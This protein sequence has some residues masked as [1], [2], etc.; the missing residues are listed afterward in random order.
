MNFLLHTFVLVDQFACCHYDLFQP[1]VKYGSIGWALDTWPACSQ[2][3][4][5]EMKEERLISRTEADALIEFA[6][7]L[8]GFLA[9]SSKLSSA[10]FE[11]YWINAEDSIAARNKLA[12]TLFSRKK[13]NGA[14]VV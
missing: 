10:D 1:S 4:I 14:T 5:E 3:R 2:P 11:K 7:W 12:L 6:D 9:R 13:S 8:Q